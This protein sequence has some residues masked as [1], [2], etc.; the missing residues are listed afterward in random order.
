MPVFD[1][2]LT[3]DKAAAMLPA[4]AINGSGKPTGADAPFVDS[5]FQTKG[6]IDAR[7]KGKATRKEPPELDYDKELKKE[8]VHI[9]N[10]GPFPHFVPLGSMGTFV[11]PACP[12]G[13]PYI[14]SLTKL[15]LLEDEIYPGFRDREPKRLRE[16]GR[17]MAIEIIG[18]GRNQDKRNSRRKWGVFVAA[19]EKPTQKE[20]DDARAE[21][22][23]L[24][25]ENVAFMD[26]VHGRDPRLAYDILRASTNFYKFADVLKLTGKEKGWLSQSEPA[27]KVKCEACHV[28]VEPDAPLCYNCKSP[29]NLEAYA[30]YRAKLKGIEE[31]PVKRGPG[32]PPKEQ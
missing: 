11:I 10:V 12:P 17:K 18:E 22:F 28:M 9:F 5:I 3:A 29:V 15:H 4:D 7:R 16:D 23:V 20:L 8:L 6:Y 30:R 19:G 14:E 27:R 24:A 13:E 25:S 26:S 31:E 1:P 21:L 32:R 2:S